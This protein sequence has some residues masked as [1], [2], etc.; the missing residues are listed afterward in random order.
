MRDIIKKVPIPTAGVA[1]GLAAL[2]NLL[3][4]YAEIAHIACGAL[5]LFLVA[6][7]VAKLIMFPSMLR[8][9]M[10][11]SVFASV[12]A[13]FFMTLMQLAGYLAPV[14]IV[15][16]L[17][18]WCSAVAGHFV[19]MTW[20]TLYYIR[21]FKLTEVFPTYFICYVGII[22]AAV[23][24][25]VFGAEA[26][27]QG[28][29]WFGFACYLVLLA[30]VTMRYIKHEIPEGAR[31]LF[32]IYA[33]PM[34]L[35]LVGYLSVMPDPNLVFVAVLMGLGQLMLI[36]VVTRV[37]KFLAL[38]FYPSYAAMTFPFVI[39]AMALGKGVQALY[40]AGYSIPALPVIEAL[41]AVETL[42][43]AVMV[44][45][46]FVHFMKFFF[47]TPKAAKAPKTR[48][49]VPAALTVEVTE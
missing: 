43:A 30:V 14:A 23:T 36:G 37:P 42:F 3:Q 4:P 44:A 33:A 8:E 1:L 40:A 41:I 47:G 2:G 45:Y 35:S 29:F 6:M 18:L 9:D 13:T 20:F 15:P 24:S 17:G 38:Q 34:G 10:K 12:S 28:I 7:L 16:A 49:E 19:L 48:P 11:N 21:R 5:S 22:V 31:P 32:C 26:F 39:S 46:V 27:G 25:P